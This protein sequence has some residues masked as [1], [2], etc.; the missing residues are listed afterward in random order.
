MLGAVLAFY[1]VTFVRD[2]LGW[3]AAG[4][5]FLFVPFAFFVFK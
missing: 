2:E 3:H 4:A 5:R 1:F